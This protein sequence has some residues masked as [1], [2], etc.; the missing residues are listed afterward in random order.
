MGQGQQIR[1]PTKRDQDSGNL[2]G[3]PAIT[4][5]AKGISVNVTGLLARAPRAGHR[6]PSRARSGCR[7]RPR[8]ERIGPSLPSSCPAWT[9]L[10]ISCWKPTAPTRPGPEGK[11]AGQRS[12]AGRTLRGKFA[13]DRVGPTRLPRAPR[14]SVRWAHRHQER[15][16]R[17]RAVDELVAKHINTTMP[18]EDLNA[19]PTIRQR[20]SV[21]RGTYEEV[22]RHHQ[23][24]G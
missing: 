10:S 2:E 3:L 9:P 12:P 17:L 13:E 7:Q 14:F 5:T 1:Q 18:E 16:L 4:A 21:H 19:R 24:A 20:R 22:P 23:Q 11:A 15:L 8:P 6:R